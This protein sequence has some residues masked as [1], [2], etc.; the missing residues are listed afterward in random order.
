MT[1]EQYI[2]TLSDQREVP[3]E[4]ELEIQRLFDHQAKTGKIPIAGGSHV[5][6]QLNLCPKK[7]KVA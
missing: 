7:G 1:Q 2:R 3:I 4:L 5:I 6:D